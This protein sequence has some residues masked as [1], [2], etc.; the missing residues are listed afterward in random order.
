MGI[1]SPNSSITNTSV[2]F[3]YLQQNGP[4]DYSLEIVNAELDDSGEYECQ[5]HTSY[6]RLRSQSAKLEV[7]QPPEEV[8]I[9]PASGS[10]GI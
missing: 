3:S 5:A 9:V 7:L 4:E 2:L 8:S 1:L 6:S 10:K